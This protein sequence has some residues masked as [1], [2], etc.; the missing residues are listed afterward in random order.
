MHVSKRVAILQSN[1]IPWR[2]YF[3]IISLVDEFI[4]YDVAQFTKNDWRNRNRIKTAQGP[5][6]LSI[7]VLTAGRS[8]QTIAETRVASPDWAEKHWRSISQA[9][10]RAPFFKTYRER[11]ESAYVACGRLQHL[12]AIN[13]LLIHAISAELDLTTTFTDASEYGVRG[14]RTE[15]LVGLCRSAGAN[16]YLTGPS[17]LDYLDLT[18]FEQARIRVEFMDYSSY[19]PY[20]QIHGAFEPHVSVIDLLLNVGATA[21]SYLR[22]SQR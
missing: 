1:Y 5:Q 19:G 11:L 17:A 14:N 7:P 12:S 8:T 15:R 21:V 6:W 16:V 2:G 9:Y 3:D 20:P 13:R 18:L 22:S 10:A 4:V